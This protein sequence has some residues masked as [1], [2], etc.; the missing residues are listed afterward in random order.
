[1]NEVTHIHLGRQVFTISV[2]AHA[3][4]KRYLDAIT[5]QVGDDSEVIEEI[6]ARMAELLAERGIHDKKVILQKDVDFLQ[7]Q[8]GAPGDFKE[9]PAE[10]AADTS[11]GKR[12]FRDLDHGLVAGVASGLEAYTGIPAII[13]RLAF[14]LLT[15]SGGLGLLVY[16]LLWLLVP[17]AKTPSDRLLMQGKPVTVGNLKKAVEQADISGAAARGANAVGRALYVVA[18]VVLGSVGALTLLITGAVLF[19]LIMA[20]AFALLR[21]GQV[22]GHVTFPVGTEEKLLLLGGLGT[23]LIGGVLALAVGIALMTLKWRLPSWLTGLLIGLFVVASGICAGYA[24]DIAPRIQDRYNALHQTHI[25]QLS[26]FKNVVLSGNNT[27]YTF[28]PDTRYFVEARFIGDPA[29]GN[30]RAVVANST[31]TIDSSAVANQPLC[32][33]LCFYNSHDITVTIHAPNLQSIV[34]HG[35]QSSF[36]ADAQPVADVLSLKV[37]GDATLSMTHINPKAAQITTLAGGSEQDVELSGLQ[38]AYEGDVLTMNG[39]GVLL[40]RAGSLELRTDRL[41]DQGDPLIQILNAPDSVDVNGKMFKSFDSFAQAQTDNS[42]D[43]NC[44][45][46]H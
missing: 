22:S 32:N 17:V 26:S 23:A 30:V 29:R 36:T 14:V 4:L 33:F 45:A 6:E 35:D 43:L 21:G 31:L 37:G 44:V 5:K 38:T 8:L 25:T 11:D 27:T 19:A 18:R 16:I 10:P 13:Y 2:A 28:V 9:E 7:H 1:M 20:T 24:A 34:L 41:C 3:E 46:V 15:F 42:T 12:F 40:A 39:G